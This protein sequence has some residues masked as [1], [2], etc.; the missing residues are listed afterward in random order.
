MCSLQGAINIPL[1]NLPEEL[2]RVADLSNGVN[3]VYCLCRRGIASA[4]ATRIL[5]EAT[6]SH[7]GIFSPKNIRGGLVAWSNEVDPSFPKY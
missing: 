4:E 2:G 7:S 1:A 5:L 3:P 6:N